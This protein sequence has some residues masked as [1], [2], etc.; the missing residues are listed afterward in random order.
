MRKPTPLDALEAH[1]N[2]VIRASGYL[3]TM[4][5]GDLAVEGVR[6]EARKRN[7]VI[8]ERLNGEIEEEGGSVVEVVEVIRRRDVVEDAED[9][10]SF[11]RADW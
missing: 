5:T 9:F 7:E 8:V 4:P 2:A 11:G 10:K 6:R 3:D 1:R